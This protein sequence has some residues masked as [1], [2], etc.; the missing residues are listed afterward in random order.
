MEERVARPE[1]AVQLTDS[2]KA[3]LE[4]ILSV[5]D[6]VRQKRLAYPFWVLSAVF[7]IVSMLGWLMGQPLLCI[8]LLPM[9]FA[10]HMIGMARYGYYKLYRLL[11][12]QN[13]IIKAAR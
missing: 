6:L 2:E 12:Y 10:A 13:A 3:L 4:R 5:P 8:A 7:N 9:G 11:H 1:Q